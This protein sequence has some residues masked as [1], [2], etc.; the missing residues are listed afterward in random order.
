[1]T[2][3][4]DLQPEEREEVPQAGPAM[5]GTS[6]Q[7]RRLWT[8]VSRSERLRTLQWASVIGLLGVVAAAIFN[9]AGFVTTG[10]WQMLVV[11][12]AMVVGAV[13]LVAANRLAL[14]GRL[15]AASNLLLAAMVFAFACGELV[16][17][18]LTIY[19]GAGGVAL[20]LLAGLVF[21]PS[22]WW[23]W[24]IVAAGYVGYVAL[25]NWLQPLP[26][27]DVQVLGV[28]TNVFVF[29]LLGFLLLASLF[30]ITRV[31][32]RL[33]LIRVR[34]PVSFA[35]VVLGSVVVIAAAGAI[36]GSQGTRQQALKQLESVVSMKEAEIEQWI[37][38]VD[39]AL[40][41][42]LTQGAVAPRMVLI[43][44]TPDL[45]ETEWTY[46]DSYLQY[47][48][49]QSEYFQDF[50]LLD[51]D[52]QVRM[53]TAVNADRPRAV[54][55]ADLIKGLAGFHIQSLLDPTSS[56]RTA[57]VALRP[58][59]DTSGSLGV[60][61]AMVDPASLNL[62]LG[63]RSWLGDTG[64]MYL[65]D[66]NRRLLTDLRFNPAR[67][68]EMNTELESLGASTHSDVSMIYTDYQGEQIVEVSR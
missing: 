22:W 26:R 17:S 67:Q 40:E 36:V 11:L 45:S 25:I 14:R 10:A 5:S 62:L 57:M 39:A 1:M 7:A 24:V 54:Y 65:I 30:S 35:L 29:A 46:P 37:G 13:G 3:L 66:H 32:Q 63:E 9:I 60:L 53:F 34:L 15:E 68:I 43:L 12:G 4:D 49:Q 42:A 55:E 48:V 31:Y 27:Y 52:G 44:Q 20:I 28:G 23:R 19:L 38:R 16:H 51:R 6:P 18:G 64:E 50:A 58:V 33:L 2:R 41:D 21:V 56:D 59:V 61:A 47:V 8:M